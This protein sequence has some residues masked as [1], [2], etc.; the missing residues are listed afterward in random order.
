MQLSPVSCY[1]IRSSTKY[2]SQHPIFQHLQILPSLGVRDNFHT[3]QSLCLC[4]FCAPVYLSIV[5]E[6]LWD[7]GGF[8]GI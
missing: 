3:A 1:I 6:I 8:H 7:S 5:G 2:L 4:T